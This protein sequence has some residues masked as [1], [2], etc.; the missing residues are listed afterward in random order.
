MLSSSLEAAAS[1]EAHLVAIEGE[2]GIGK[3]AIVRQLL[4]SCPRAVALAASGDEG[5]M[6][7]AYGVIA[8]LA[9][10]AGLPATEGLP[11]LV[12][13]PPPGADPLAVGAQLLALLASLQEAASVVVMVIDDLQWVDEPSR[14]ALRFV[15]RRLVADRVL[16]ICSSRCGAM[17]SLDEGWARLLTSGPAVQRLRLGGL[18][19][20]DLIQL[21]EALHAGPLS[22]QGARRL[23]AHTGGNPLFS[24]ALLE[25]LPAMAFEAHLQ[26]PLP[27]PASL[28][29]AL[30]PRL[31]GLDAEARALVEAAA[32]LGVSMPLAHASEVAGVTDGLGAFE[33]ASEAGLLQVGGPSPAEI[34]FPHQLMRQ[35]IGEGLGA[36]RARELHLRAARVVEAD[37]ALV[38]RVAASAG[39]D[40]AL[41]L[42]LEAAARQA[43]SRRAISRAAA[44][45]LHAAQLSATSTEQAR[46]LIQS[47][48]CHLQVS[49]VS[50]AEQ[51]RGPVERLPPSAARDA[52]LGQLALLQ[53]RAPEAEA[54][55][56]SAWGRHDPT[57]EAS[58]GAAAALALGTLYV[59]GRS[60][61]AQRWTALALDG[62]IDDGYWRSAAMYTHG[63]ARAITEGPTAAL[64]A[65]SVLDPAPGAVPPDQIDALTARGMV[66]TWADDLRGAAADLAVAAERVRAGEMVKYP[67]QPLAFLAEAEMGLGNWDDAVT[68]GELAVALAHDAER[69]WDYPYLHAIAAQVP[70]Y[71]GD[72][73]QAAAHVDAAERSAAAFGARTAMTFAAGARCALGF[74]QD[75]PV[76]VARAGEVALRGGKPASS[77]RLASKEPAGAAIIG[78]AWRPLHIWALIRLGRF[79]EAE[80]HLG[81]FLSAAAEQ[82]VASATIRVG[83]LAGILAEARGD[84]AGAERAFEEALQADE[85]IELPFWRSL[86]HLDWGRYQRRRGRRRR[87]I[88]SLAAA[89]EGFAGLGA[90]PFLQTCDVELAALGMRGRGDLGSELSLTQQ[91]AA[92]ARHVAA[93][94]SNRE[95]A[96]E[97]YVSPKTV[98]FHLGNVF[99]KLGIHSRSQLVGALAGDSRR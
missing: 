83:R 51:L 92:V 82:K 60:E 49:A 4:R 94:K 3:S 28:A 87:A 68:H 67:G 81:E 20:Q 59:L 48:D 6:T 8:Q 34:A 12:S 50:S 57:S 41:S 17:R 37:Q 33:R 21:S 85:A 74:A 36:S 58:V 91:E 22:I 52:A 24:R 96:A 88:E 90:R 32:I 78:R 13:G 77:G 30:V 93:G 1:G 19:E 70:A 98:E 29:D 14:R 55:L 62:P 80:S 71:R 61:E 46:L 75:D 73:A 31:G 42:E 43:R 9:A 56:L 64:G 97:L 25:D 66:K 47:M 84:H 11:L 5:E 10:C 89:R 86:T 23:A 7:L 79:E 53:A 16:V 54:L 76:A 35:A 18:Q 15:L 44:L 95:V 63:I 27:A 2:A 39:P 99:A 72:W 45:Y 38:H 69:T 40:P 65:F 26:G